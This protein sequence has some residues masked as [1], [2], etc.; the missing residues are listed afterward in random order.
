MHSI[1]PSTS[2]VRCL[3]S[4]KKA[5]G[6]KQL[7][8]CLYAALALSVPDRPLLAH[9][10]SDSIHLSGWL[11]PHYP[12]SGVV[13]SVNSCL[14][15]GT[16]GTLRQVVSISAS[17]DTVDLSAVPLTCSTITLTSGEI[18]ESLAVLTFVGPTNH[19]VTITTDY[20]GRIFKHT[21]AVNSVLSITDLTISHGRVY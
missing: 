4:V 13:R 3:P 20:S 1:S 5:L 15:D 16:T 21:N 8:A 18:N 10:A 9:A 2:R 14:D 17:G 11:V 12:A 7:V 19:R 6:Q